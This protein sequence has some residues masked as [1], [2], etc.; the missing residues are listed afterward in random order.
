MT[1]EAISGNLETS[2]SPRHARAPPVPR[3]ARPLDL[4]RRVR[5][6]DGPDAPRRQ[7]P[8]ARAAQRGAERAPRRR[9]RPRRRHGLH[10]PPG[11]DRDAEREHGRLLP[12]APARRDGRAPRGPADPARPPR[13]QLPDGQSGQPARDAP[14]H[15]RARVRRVARPRRDHARLAH[16]GA[17]H[18]FAGA[19]VHH[20]PVPPDAR[21]VPHALL[22]AAHTRARAHPQGKPDQNRADDRSSSGRT[23][24]CPPQR[25]RARSGRCG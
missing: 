9:L 23:W 16:R 17:V 2:P 11:P 7:L 22:P 12:P 15:R 25:C 20:A 19:R 5:V 24:A 3:R 4:G 1:A 14:R 18:R 6:A 8:D 21:P 10:E 13:R